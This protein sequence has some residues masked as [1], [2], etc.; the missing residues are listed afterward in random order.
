M[1]VE[2]KPVI[3]YTGQT[4]RAKS[5]VFPAKGLQ[6]ADTDSWKAVNRAWASG[7]SVWRDGATGEFSLTARAGFQERK[8]PRVALYRSEIPV[9]DE[10]WTRWMFEQFGFAYQSLRN[11]EILKGGLRERFDVIV[12]PD[13]SPSTIHNGYRPGTMPREYVGGLG[14]SG[15]HALL[16]FARAGGTLIF[17]NDSTDYAIG[18]LG[19]PL[20][21]VVGGL[22]NR[23][24]FCPG[25]LL[26]VKLDTRHAIT[27]G[28]PAD[29]AI[30][31]EGNAAWDVP[32]GSTAKPLAQYPASGVLASGW[33]LGERY[34][35]GKSALVEVPM[36]QG[37]AVL[38]GMRPQYRAQ[39]YQSVKLLF[40]A[41]LGLP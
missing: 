22:G 15:A 13:Q 21:N 23:D 9:M 31:S 19:V 30:W 39:T 18:H 41:M 7:R 29:I 24:F 38:F 35:A 37:R 2:V 20:R 34:L 25:S 6:A 12:F 33:L 14:E 3:A 10:G 5:Y 32:A 11:G 36:G 17:L 1:G 28:L 26:N 27:Q 16:D 40:N 8:R 4:A